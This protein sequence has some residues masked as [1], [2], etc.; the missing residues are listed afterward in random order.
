MDTIK[1]L[2]TWVKN[3]YNQYTTG[4][5]YERSEGNYTDCFSDGEECSR[6]WCAYEIGEILGMKLE[7]PDSE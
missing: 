1:A 3:N 7:E 5:T 6:S 2:E 4:W